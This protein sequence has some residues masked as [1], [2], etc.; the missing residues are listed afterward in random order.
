MRPTPYRS[1]FLPLAAAAFFVVY[2]FLS[3][4][5]PLRFNSPDENSNYFFIGTFVADGRLWSFEPL[6]LVAPGLIHPRS[7]RVVDSFLVPGG[8]LGLPVLYGAAAKVFGMGVVPFLTPL[9]AALSA[10][11]LSSIVRK[12]FGERAGLF[13]GLLLLIDPVWWYEASRP[14]MPNIL[15][16]ALVIFS[17][18]FLLAEPLLNARQGRPRRRWDVFWRADSAL[19]GALCGLALA[20]RLSEV[21]WLALAAAV[22]VIASVR[23]LPWYKPALFAF[24]VT[25]T[26]L[27]FLFLNQ[28]LY[29]SLSGTGYGPGFG[30]VSVDDMPAGRG[31]R[32][33]G[34]LLPYLFPLGFAPR[35]ALTN[36]WTYG[37]S[38]FWWWSL[39]VGAALVAAAVK[40]VRLRR[41]GAKLARPAVI[42]ACL[43]GLVCLWLILFYGSW[44]IRD[45]PDPRAVTIGTSYFRYWLPIFVLSVVPVAW[46]LAALVEKLSAGRRWLAGFVLFAGL[47]VISAWAVFGAKEEGLLALRAN[48]IRYDQEVSRA[49]ARTERNALIVVDRADKLFFPERAVIYPFR[50]DATMSALTELSDHVPLYY[51]GISLPESDLRYLREEKLPPLGL[52][53]DPLESFRE[54]SLYALHIAPIK[55]RP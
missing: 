7:V 10:L 37:L 17:A 25:L 43:G 18:W 46:A 51:Y 55:A 8:F 41:Q 14:L 54:E 11:A 2:S 44:T 31:A 12:Y 34:P 36:F 15:F 39:I 40:A 38:F 19:A 30:G 52:T 29:G 35:T 6:N 16:T 13:A 22:L 28:S 5:A 20:V 42:G 23:K 3:L 53:I 33:L 32:L 24:F 21:Y 45:N 48:L 26:F 47:A 50:S 27:P 49:V 1:W 4:A 9:L